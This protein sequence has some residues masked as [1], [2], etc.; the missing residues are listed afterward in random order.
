MYICISYSIVGICYSNVR[1]IKTDERQHEQLIFSAKEHKLLLAHI[2]TD[3]SDPAAGVFNH[4]VIR[5]WVHLF[6]ELPDTFI[7]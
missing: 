2:N 7:D 6:P 3:P 5:V 1:V 4:W